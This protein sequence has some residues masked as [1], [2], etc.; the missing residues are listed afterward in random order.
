MEF[1]PRS[2]NFT[3]AASHSCLH[4]NRLPCY[5]QGGAQ[6]ALAVAPSRQDGAGGGA[7]QQAQPRY[8]LYYD[9]KKKCWLSV[10][11]ES[12]AGSEAAAAF[13]AASNGEGMPDIAERAQSTTQVGQLHG[14]CFALMLTY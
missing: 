11:F 4:T 13:A 2:A 1:R 10:D 14:S 3:V 5:W 6:G 8:G 9:E 7:S 12:T